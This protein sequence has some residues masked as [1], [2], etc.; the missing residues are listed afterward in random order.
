MASLFNVSMFWKGRWRRVTGC[1][2]SCGVERFLE[3][4]ETIEMKKSQSLCSLS[5][6][7]NSFSV[8]F[9]WPYVKL[10]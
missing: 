5:V 7:I 6:T 1:F 9:I 8:C 2:E 4:W 3:V 10:V